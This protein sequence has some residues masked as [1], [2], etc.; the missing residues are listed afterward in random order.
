MFSKQD[1]SSSLC[2]GLSRSEFQKIM[3]MNKDA[4]HRLPNQEKMP[5]EGTGKG[6]P[7]AHQSQ[8]GG[9]GHVGRHLENLSYI[10]H[11]V[12]GKTMLSFKDLVLGCFDRI[13]F[14]SLDFS[15]PAKRKLHG[16]GARHCTRNLAC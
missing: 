11:H 14:S 16:K 4:R 6:S 3:T 13:S 1:R 12:V 2:L 10:L 7:N 5:C 9:G 15:V 8:Q